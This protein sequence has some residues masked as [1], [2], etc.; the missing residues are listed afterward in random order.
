MTVPA[1]VRL[2]R[3]SVSYR[4]DPSLPSRAVVSSGATVVFETHDARAGVLLD[5]AP[6]SLFELPLPTPGQGNPLTGPLQVEG[7][8][9][10]D[11]L[12]VTI[13]QIV[14]DEAGWCG[15]HAHVG[16][17][18]PGRIPRPLGRV[19]S[20]H[21]DMVHFSDAIALPTSPMIGCIGTAPEGGDPPLAGLPGRYGGNM[22]HK[23]VGPGASVYLPVF[24]PGGQL[25]VGDVHACQGDGELSGV[26]LEIGSQVT[27]TV[28]VRQD[29]G[30]RWPWVQ[31]GDRIMVMT[32]SMKF[33]DARREAVGEMLAAL[34]DQ[35]GL[36]PAEGL[37]LIS[38]AGDL[39]VGQAFG[40][41]E[42]TLRLEMPAS[43]GL[44]PA[45]HRVSDGG[46]GNPGTSA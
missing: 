26:A 3:D 11:A 5:R 31:A 20:V 39:R 34:E 33:A 6:G 36:E 8:E 41:M 43:L 4:Y 13:D 32:T 16:P 44:V 24:V 30:L 37:A 12:V 2:S 18:E 22:D 19:C 17:L 35:L 42:L 29:A 1:A 27:A 10:G 21:D 14:L 28:S 40:G 15:G 7:A 46:P 23:T 9:P 25:Y 38:V 45:G